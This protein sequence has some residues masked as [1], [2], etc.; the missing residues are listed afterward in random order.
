[1][2]NLTSTQEK[3]FD[4][5]SDD[6]LLFGISLRNPYVKNLWH[7]TLFR[8]QNSKISNPISIDRDF[9]GYSDISGEGYLKDEYEALLDTNYN[10]IHD[11]KK[12]YTQSKSNI[13]VNDS[14]YFSLNNTMNIDRLTLGAK[15]SIGNK[16][17][18]K[19]TA[20][21]YLG[22]YSNVLSGSDFN[23]PT[24]SNSFTTWSLQENYKSLLWTERGD[25]NNQNKVDFTNIDLSVMLPLWGFELR[26]DLGIYS[27][28]T[29]NSKL[30]IFKKNRIFIEIESILDRRRFLH[31][32]FGRFSKFL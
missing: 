19:N 28:Q 4:N 2:S 32:I 23:D 22:S 29:Q 7:S 16:L 25:F 8:F 26:A 6:E 18:S 5:N 1:M 12:S 11:L 9:D 20:S 31:K 21:S 10:G 17:I 3:I 14:Y 27:N 13:P 30:Q 24:F 15:I